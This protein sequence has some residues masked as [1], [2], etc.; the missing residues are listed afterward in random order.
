MQ[1]KQTTKEIGRSIW[2]IIMKREIAGRC[3]RKIEL[4]C[5]LLSKPHAQ[6]QY[7]IQTANHSGSTNENVEQYLCTRSQVR[8][9]VNCAVVLPTAGQSCTSMTSLALAMIRQH[10]GCPPVRLGWFG[11]ISRR[12]NRG[13]KKAKI[14][15][16]I[17]QFLCKCTLIC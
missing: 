2:I 15:R 10:F 4:I 6:L 7:E 3:V 1:N 14:C 16:K 5:W 9:Y 12:T 17:T 11:L 8:V 13:Q